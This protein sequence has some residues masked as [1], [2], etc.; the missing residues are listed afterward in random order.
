MSLKMKDSLQTSI[1]DDETIDFAH[2]P[3]DGRAHV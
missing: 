2:L 3:E 1:L